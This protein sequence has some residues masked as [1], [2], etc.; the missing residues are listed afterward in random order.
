M[1]FPPKTFSY[2]FLYEF[3]QSPKQIL[4]FSKQFESAKSSEKYSNSYLQLIVLNTKRGNCFKDAQA[5]NF[6]FLM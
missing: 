4:I 1:S 5:V 3:S 2:F 6:F